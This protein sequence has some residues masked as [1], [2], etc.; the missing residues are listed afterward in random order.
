M[1]AFAQANASLLWVS[2]ELQNN[3]ELVMTAVAQNGESLM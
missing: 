2:K 3:K 1:T